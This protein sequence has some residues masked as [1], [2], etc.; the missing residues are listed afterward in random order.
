MYVKLSVCLTLPERKLLFK[1]PYQYHER[2]AEKT[3]FDD[4]SMIL[5]EYEE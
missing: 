3:L 5:R 2:K 4:I 1:T